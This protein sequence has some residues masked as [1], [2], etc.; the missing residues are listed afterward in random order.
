MIVQPVEFT[1]VFAANCYFYIDPDTK[2]GFVI[3]PSAH[4][5]QLFDIAGTNHWTIEKILLT[6]SHLDHIAAAVELSERL[7]VPFF[8]HE[9]A[10]LYLSSPELAAHFTDRQVL[11]KM[12]FFDHDTIT[13]S[14]NAQVKLR[15]L[16]TPGH[17]LD[18]VVFYDAENHL[19][20][21]GDTIFRGAIGR[22]D[23]DGSG[24]DAK[25]LYQSIRQHILSLPPDTVLYPG[26]G[27]MT[28]VKNEKGLF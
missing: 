13:L 22:T 6:H 28:T 8:G 18:S 19:A 21:T 17:T 11:E 14:A 9:N 25:A 24:G 15:I 12:Q 4:A 20:F 5:V 1:D 16:H 10:K 7:K 26:H 23:I 2:H 3:D 27:P